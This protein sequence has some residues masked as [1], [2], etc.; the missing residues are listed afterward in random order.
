[1]KQKAILR[2]VLITAVSA[3]VISALSSGISLYIPI[4]NKNIIDKGIANNKIDLV[5]RFCIILLILNISNS[6]LK[7]LSNGIISQLGIRVV[8]NVKKA[9]IGKVFKFPMAFFDA[10]NSGQLTQRIH[11]I[12]GLSVLFSPT[13][14]HILT[15][16]SSCIGGIIV[17]LNI[18][19]SI[20]LFYCPA[21]PLVAFLSY[22]IASLLQNS[23]METADLECE[24]NGIVQESI[25]GIAEVK[26]LNLGGKK[27]R[28]IN[29]LTSKVYKK[30]LWQ[31]LFV[32]AGSEIMAL[33][34]ILISLGITILCANLIIKK[35]MTIGEYLAITQYTSLILAPAQLVA[36]AYISLQPGIVSFKR[37]KELNQLEVEEY[38]EGNDIEEINTIDCKN[39]TFGYSDKYVLKNINFSI[40]R[41]QKFAVVG[42]NG[43]GK[44]TLAKL[45]LGFYNNYEGHINY[46]NTDMKSFSVK[47]LRKEISIV[48]QDVF[49]FNGTLFDNIKCAA[50]EADNKDIIEALKQCGLV[51]DMT[52][53][54]ISAILYMPIMEGG[55][56]L[57]G[58]QKQRVAIARALSRK[59]SVL[60]F[61]EATAH[62]DQE[63]KESIKEFLKNSLPNIICIIITH[64][65]DFAKLADEVLLLQ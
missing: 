15:S 6:L 21:I 4:L 22:K 25:Q 3:I 5:I 24:T 29:E 19:P 37:I 54:E 48:F 1:M 9:F 23:L 2:S 28:E 59:P 47:S 65:D 26:S 45:L 13:F 63:T 52:E 40:R 27:E 43:S 58:G 46:N 7:F 62:L 32:S 34:N 55:K 11:E 16:V 61:D 31:N 10:R 17:V 30:T 42:P 18:Q 38:S 35:R 53:E 41:G 33:L 44:T 36:S 49:L 57:S 8:S 64:D 12:D 60:V 39:V 51:K 20:V 56:N 14:L 50:P